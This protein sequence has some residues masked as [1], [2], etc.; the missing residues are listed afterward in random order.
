MTL[1]QFMIWLIGGGS[2]IA[3]AW[4]M[5][6]IDW[7]QSLTPKMKRL[8]MFGGSAVLGLG[9]LAV[10]TFVPPEVLVQLNPWFMV[11]TAIFLSVFLNQAAHK[12]DPDR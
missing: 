5:E 7:F 8:V 3:F 11:V 9:A 6:Q 12:Y 4:I 10:I 1:E 2:V